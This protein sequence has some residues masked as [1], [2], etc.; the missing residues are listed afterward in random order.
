MNERGTYF[1]FHDEN[2]YYFFSCSTIIESALHGAFRKVALLR[3]KDFV[4]FHFLLLQILTLFL[5]IWSDS[6][7]V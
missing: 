6:S 2:P 4:F 5:Y 3:Q 1:F 7:G